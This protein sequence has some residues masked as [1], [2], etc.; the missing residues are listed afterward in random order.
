MEGVRY[1]EYTLQLEPGSKLF[2]YTDGVAEA[3]DSNN[4][5]Y[6]TDRM[7]A[8]LREKENESPEAILASVNRSIDAFVGRAPQFDDLTMLCVE[9]RGPA[10]NS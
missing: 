8:A 9:Y 5:L 4:Q 7:I 10:N 3:T 2:T 6:G 1:R